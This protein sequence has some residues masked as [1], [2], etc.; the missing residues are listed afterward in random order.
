[1]NG[2]AVG[3][4]PGPVAPDFDPGIDGARTA[5]GPTAGLGA[6]GRTVRRIV[7]ELAGG[8]YLAVRAAV[9]TRVVQVMRPA[10][11]AAEDGPVQI[12]LYRMTPR[13]VT[14]AFAGG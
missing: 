13:S 11:H 1:V 9:L 7:T 8:G 5:T 12:G 2:R 3:G 10:A 4:A 14:R 6:T